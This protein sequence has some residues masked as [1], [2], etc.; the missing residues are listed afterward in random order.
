MLVATDLVIEDEAIFE[1]DTTFCQFQ[2]VAAAV[3]QDHLPVTF[4]QVDNTLDSDVTAF[5]EGIEQV[6]CHLQ[7][8]VPGDQSSRVNERLPSTA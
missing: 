6:L 1:C 2:A 5:L 8:G 7:V 3:H 4:V